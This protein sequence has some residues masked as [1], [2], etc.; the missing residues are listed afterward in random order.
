MRIAFDSQTF[1]YQTYGGISRYF[2]RLALG[3]GQIGQQVGIFAPLYRNAYLP[4]L[5][6]GMI[7][8]Y[9]LRRYW[10]KT[11]RLFLAYNHT[12]ARLQIA[13]W[14]PDIVHETYYSRASS[15]PRSC[16]VVVTVLDMIHEMFPGEFHGRD[17]TAEIKLQAIAR[18]DH[19]ICISENTKRDLMRLHG[20]PETRISVVY[21]GFDKFAIHEQRAAPEAVQGKPFLLY[22][23]ARGGY[24]NF[25]GFLKAF[26][27]S[28]RL[29]T[30]FDIVAFG[31]SRFSNE[32]LA[33]MASLGLERGQVHHQ[34]GGDDVLGACYGLARAFVYPS[35][36]EGFGIP[37]LEAMARS[38]PV[39]CSNTSSLPEIVGPAG[40][41]FDPASPG[42]MCRAIEAVV[43]S[44]SRADALRS[45]GTSQ[46]SRFSW[47]KCARET[48]NIY[49]SL[50]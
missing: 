15:A 39:V 19:V 27:S 6:K 28:G 22:V 1:V 43:Y 11:T 7:H 5:P 18:A 13:R 40:E 21:L 20:T 45:A 12:M 42:D 35:L 49:Q 8:G 23:G 30:D 44:D 41:Y 48:L 31:G 47:D 14:K 3:L 10:P 33:L 29:R 9:H 32:E 38:C 17:N 25:A 34:S 16:P 24:K 36:Y 50:T 2:T 37:P 26:A 4:A 46:L